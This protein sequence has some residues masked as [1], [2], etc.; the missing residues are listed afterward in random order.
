MAE[1]TKNT[2]TQPVDNSAELTALKAENA[3]LKAE[4]TA[5]KSNVSILDGQ[6]A[7]LQGSVA[8]QDAI[9]ADLQQKLEK[10]ATPIVSQ[11]PVVTVGKDKYQVTLKQFR[12]KGVEYKAEDLAKNPAVVKAL[13]E[14]KVEFLVRIQ[15]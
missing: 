8:E 12:F 2:T 1:E 15:A 3:A 9:I 13:L 4:N 5:L 11:H 14:A 10:A 7:G 6:V